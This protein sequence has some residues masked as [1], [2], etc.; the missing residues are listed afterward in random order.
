MRIVFPCIIITLKI[1]CKICRAL[2]HQ[3]ALIGRVR[4]DSLLTLMAHMVLQEL[5]VI[6]RLA[7]LLLQTRDWGP[8]PGINNITF[9]ACLIVTKH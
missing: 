5:F 1:L 2:S 7:T 4:I 6:S 8:V 9:N 3:P